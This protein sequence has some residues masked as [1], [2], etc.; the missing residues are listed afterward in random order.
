MSRSKKR[1][2][3]KQITKLDI[4]DGVR[5]ALRFVVM[6]LETIHAVATLT[7]DVLTREQ[8]ERESDVAHVIRKGVINAL[9]I[10]MDVLRE[11]AGERES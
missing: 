5:E 2:R 3:T 6:H 11:M 4:P 9:S 7:H 1:R 8:S 10:Q